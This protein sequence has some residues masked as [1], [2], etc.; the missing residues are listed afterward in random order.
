[1]YEGLG[2]GRVR[3]YLR[4]GN[5]VFDAAAGE[6]SALGARIERRILAEFGFAVPVLLRSREELGAIIAASPYLGR[7]GVDPARL[8]VTFLAEA[9]ANPDLPHPAPGGP[10]QFRIAGREIHLHCP[11]GYGKTRLSN[12]FFEKALAITATTRNWN[13]VNNLYAMASQAP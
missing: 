4:S 5:V 11:E 2:L 3:S 13:S 1:M 8:Y 9:P 12:T 6:P 7:E 10:D